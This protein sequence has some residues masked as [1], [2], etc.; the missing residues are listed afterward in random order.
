MGKKAKYSTLEALQDS[1][2]DATI[3]FE[4]VAVPTVEERQQEQ[5]DTFFLNCTTVGNKV[6]DYYTCYDEA[7]AD[8]ALHYSKT[9]KETLPNNKLVG[10]MYGS[11]YGGRYE[12]FPQ[13]HGQSAVHKV[14][15]SPYVDYVHSAYHY[16]NRSIGGTHYS[17]HSADSV[18]L[19]NKLMIDQID[20]KTHLYT[21]HDK[22]AT[23][24]LGVCPIIKTRRCLGHC[25]KLSCLLV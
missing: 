25:K 24:R 11:S 2:N 14:L 23:N 7:L 20:T 10:L 6:S 8:L 4:T 15:Q 19:H 18:L 22:N 3:T 5:G 13:H 16:Y 12:D 21:G 17:Q 9:I 1:W